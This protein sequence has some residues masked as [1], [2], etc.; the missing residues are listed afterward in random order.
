MPDEHAVLLERDG[1]HVLR[2]ERLLE[3]PLERVWRALTDPG[4]LGAWHPTP[5][6]LEPR[7][8]GT[9]TFLAAPG[10]PEMGSGRVLACEAP[11]L[12]VHS[13]GEDEL[14]WT[15]ERRDE[16]CLLTLEHSFA[17]RMKAARDG[18]GWHICLA[19]LAAAMEG[20]A[21]PDRG[22]AQSLPDGWS[23]LNDD[24]QRRFGIT[25]EQATPVP[26]L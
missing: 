16:G 18:A 17:D 24:Y 12:L 3:H 2:F 25:P 15:L 8:G 6:L 20:H 9:V 19:A 10:A 5:F 22:S 4:E 1:R 23:E 26:P 13:W 11:V 21:A 7:A 14:R